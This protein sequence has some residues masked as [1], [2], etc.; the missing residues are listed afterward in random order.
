MVRMLIV[1]AALTAL[2]HCAA[3]AQEIRGRDGRYLGRVER[4]PVTGYL[5]F[6]DKRGKYRGRVDDF[7]PGQDYN[8][9][10]R[11]DGLDRGVRPQERRFYCAYC[12][13]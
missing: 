1:A 6:Y 12:R 3:G 7:R 13:D 4:S 2:T 11:R 10:P 5:E 9:P 8:V